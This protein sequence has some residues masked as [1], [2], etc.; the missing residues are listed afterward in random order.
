MT[1]LGR[2][3]EVLVHWLCGGITD[4]SE[5]RHGPAS[6]YKQQGP[7]FHSQ[8]MMK[9]SEGAVCPRYPADSST[10]W[11]ALSFHPATVSDRKKG[12]AH[13]HRREGSV[14]S[15]AS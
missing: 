2:A 1:V 7:H 11:K 12:Y 14:D 5:P 8:C 4:Q 13:G 3:E 15:N 10:S 9:A 6:K